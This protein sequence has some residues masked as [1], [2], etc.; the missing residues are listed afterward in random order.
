M[1]IAM[2]APLVALVLAAAPAAALAAPAPA[3]PP[4]AT[5]LHVP[6]SATAPHAAVSLVA[7]IDAAAAEPDLVARFRR[8]G[9]AAWRDVPFERSSAGGWYAIIPAADVVPPGLEYY[10][11]GRGGAGAPAEALHFASAEH[12]QPIRVDPDLYDRLEALDRART[13]GRREVVALDVDG[14][15]F[16]N[17]YHLGDR[18]LRAEL[19]WTHHAFRQLHAVGFGFGAIDGETPAA[20]GAEAQ[21]AR[22]AARYGFAE[23]RVR[24]HPSLFLDARATLGVSDDGFLR[25]IGGAI[26]FGK[27]WRSNVAVGG[28]M[29]DSLGPT[30]FVR[31]QWDTAAPLLMGAS[32]VRTDLPGAV[33]A[34]D[35][36]YVRYDVAYP[37][38]PAFTVRASVSY[39]ARDGAARFGG[40]IGTQLAF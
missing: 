38:V 4:R 37:V 10:I 19:R 40:G 30:A 17:R 13:G 2:R 6:V 39:G 15:D 5:V 23:L 28:E 34:A 8:I 33:I 14:H 16:G 11:A 31:L 25:G 24:P 21:S 26:T 35:G 12:P 27:P 1:K 29:L 18:F 9:A 36:L 32:I 3:P 7:V 20:A 22:H